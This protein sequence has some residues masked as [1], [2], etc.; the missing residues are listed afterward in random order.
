MD[1]VNLLTNLINGNEILA[2]FLI[3]IAI[4]LEGELVL[5]FSGILAHLGVIDFRVLLVVAFIAIIVKTLVGYKI[6]MYFFQ[7]YPQSRIFNILEQKVLFFLPRFKEKPFWSIFISKFIYGIN[8]FTMI[9][10]GFIKINFKTYLKAEFYS[11]IIWVLV[12]LSV[13]YLFS[14]TA[15]AI[16]HD[17]KKFFLLLIFFFIGF[18]LL[19]QVISFTY[20][21]WKNLNRKN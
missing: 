13:G 5:V 3:F 6:G 11:S 20:Q 2:Y 10:S 18:I 17:I 8:N 14:F 1:T 12:L 16:T 9:F 4:V 19:E 7:R 15:L 21:L